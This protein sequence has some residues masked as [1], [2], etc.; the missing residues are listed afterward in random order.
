MEKKDGPNRKTWAKTVKFG[1]NTEIDVGSYGEDIF[2]LGRNKNEI[3]DLLVQFT[4]KECESCWKYQEEHVA[5]LKR[6][7]LKELADKLKTY[8]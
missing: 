2:Y 4:R 5:T 8:A 3:I 6:Q 1:K 7:F